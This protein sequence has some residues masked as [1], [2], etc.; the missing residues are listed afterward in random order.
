VASPTSK[1]PVA[2][3]KLPIRS[4]GRTLG[5]SVLRA[6]TLD[7]GL[8]VAL[9][10]HAREVVMLLDNRGRPVAGW[11]RTIP[12]GTCWQLLAAAD[13][14]ARLLCDAP[15]GIDDDGLQA[16]VTRI[17]ALR[18]DARAVSGWPIDVESAFTGRMIGNDLEL[19]VRP[20]GGDMAETAT[21][22]VHVVEVGPHGAVARTG[23][24]VS[25]ECCENDF[26]L[27]PD[28][29]AVVTTHNGEYDSATTDVM[30]FD[31]DGAG[32]GSPIR[33]DGVASGPSFDAR[34]RIYLALTPPTGSGT[35]R[36]ELDHDGNRVGPQPTLW[37]FSATP[38]SIGMDDRQA[39]G[40]LVVSDDG[41]AFVL[42]ETSGTAVLAIDR[43]DTVPDSWPYRSRLGPQRDDDCGDDTGCPSLRVPPVAG[44]DGTLFVALAAAEGSSAGGRIVALDRSAHVRAGWPVILKRPGSAFW[45]LTPNPTGGL[46]ALAIE[47]E[48]ND[49]SATMLSISP[50]G[51]VRWATTIVEP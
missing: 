20:Y 38:S 2:T 1:P 9:T 45:L 44:A 4:S 21:E 43:A 16:P 27:G 23:P 39:S 19:L 8:Y 35:R 40:E 17:Y 11:P 10:H 51:S 31:V 22:T 29:T 50:A 34:G 46:W 49:F 3:V 6:P 36:I 12:A 48:A 18:P 24:E 37:P 28:G 13:G 7:G 32:S 25:F 47:P 30:V 33:L 15:T 14:T 42:D 26:G 41:V 5:S